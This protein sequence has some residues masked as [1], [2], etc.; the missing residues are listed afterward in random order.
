MAKRGGR[1]RRRRS[2]VPVFVN[3][4]SVRT[5]PV[6][7]TREVE[8]E[9]EGRIARLLEAPDQQPLRALAKWFERWSL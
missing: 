7:G 2:H 9:Y 4:P 6:S 1:G 5:S 8:T 3:P